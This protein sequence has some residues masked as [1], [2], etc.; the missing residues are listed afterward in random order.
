[1]KRGD[2]T[3]EV[4]GHLL[5]ASKCQPC[6]GEFQPLGV[7]SLAEEASDSL[8]GTVLKEVGTKAEE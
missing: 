8:K 3:D 7:P 6:T 4:H 1:M 5:T 2:S